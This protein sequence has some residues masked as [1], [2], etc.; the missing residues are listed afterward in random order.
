MNKPTR[1]LWCAAGLVAAAAFYA[2]PV[3]RAADSAAAPT[4]TKDVA[5]IMRENNQYQHAVVVIEKERGRL[6]FD[7]PV[8]YNGNFFQN[9]H[10]DPK[11]GT[12]SMNRY[13][14]RVY[15]TPDEKK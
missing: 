9:L 2:S 11:N 15:I 3:V 10:V 12:I 5:P 8:V 6:V 7:K 4:F 1:L 14:I 13:D